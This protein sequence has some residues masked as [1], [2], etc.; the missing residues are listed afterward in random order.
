[1]DLIIVRI[2][3]AKTVPAVNSR[4]DY[5]T[6]FRFV[7]KVTYPQSEMIFKNVGRTNVGLGIETDAQFAKWLVDNFG[8]GRYH[9]HL[10]KKG[11]RGWTFYSFDCSKQNR[12]QQVKKEPTFKEREEEAN[13]REYKKKKRELG[14]AESESEREDLQGEIKEIEEDLD[15]SDILEEGNRHTHVKIKPFRNT[16]PLHKEHGYEEYGDIIKSRERGI[17]NSIW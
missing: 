12:F 6:E 16:Q 17:D 14:E 1:M 8:L 7:H 13:L 10:F 5:R 9:I 3:K 4:F 15:V 11:V 2:G